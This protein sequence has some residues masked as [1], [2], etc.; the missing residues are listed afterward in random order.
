LKP[1]AG[2]SGEPVLES[3]VMELSL[4]LVNHAAPWPSMAMV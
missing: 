4:G 3:L 2:D 1:P